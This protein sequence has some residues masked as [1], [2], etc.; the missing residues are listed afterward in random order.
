MLS[1]GTSTEESQLELR[2]RRAGITRIA[3][4]ATISVPMALDAREVLVPAS[5]ARCQTI[6]MRALAD[7]PRIVS[8][9]LTAVEPLN[10]QQTVGSAHRQILRLC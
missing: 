4:L 10:A 5:D 9:T 2:P 8:V 3:A 1:G 6:S 7:A